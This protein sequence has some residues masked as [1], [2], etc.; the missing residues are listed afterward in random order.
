MGRPRQYTDEQVIDAIRKAGGVVT[1]AAKILGCTR[2]TVQRRANEV[3]EVREVIEDSREELIDEAEKSLRAAVVKGDAWAVCFALKTI[4]KSRG[5]VERQEV[6][7]ISDPQP[8][9]LELKVVEGVT[10]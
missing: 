3:A 1:D 5:Y 10:E 8:V 4:G 9:E 6:K 2:R 7:D